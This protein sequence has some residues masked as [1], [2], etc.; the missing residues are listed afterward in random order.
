MNQRLNQK[1]FWIDKRARGKT[2][3]L[4]VKKFLEYEEHSLKMSSTTLKRMKSQTKTYKYTKR[5]FLKVQEKDAKI[6]IITN[7]LQLAIESPPTKTQDTMAYHRWW[8]LLL[9][10]HSQNILKMIS[11]IYIYKYKMGI[12]KLINLI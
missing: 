5:K 8:Y 6:T 2:L 4:H 12:F 3:F 1:K 10:T 9:R 11:N 7:K